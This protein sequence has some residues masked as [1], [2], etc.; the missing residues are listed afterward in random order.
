MIKQ[1]KKLLM[2]PLL[3][4]VAFIF[5]SSCNNKSTN[6][7]STPI[8][9]NGFF[10]GTIIDIKIYN[11]VDEEIFDNIFSILENIENKMSINLEE[12]EVIN[13]NNNAGNSFVKVSDET[14]YVV[15]KGLYYSELSKGN[16]DISIGPL[17]KLWGIG[18]E[19]AKVPTTEELN[20]TLENVNY[21]NVSID[22]ENSSVKLANGN[23][24]LDL[25]GIAKGYA[26]DVIASYLQE[27]GVT[28]AII[29]LGGNV[30]ALGSKGG[31]N[32]S[33]GVQ[34]P[35]D[36]RGSYFGVL[37]VKDK[38]VVTSGIYERYF[39]ENG[40]SYHHILSPYTGYPINNSLVSVSIITDN[41]IDADALST[42]TFSLGLQEGI[43]LIESIENT[44]AIFV[45]KDY[46]V[47]TTSGLKDNFTITNNDFKLAN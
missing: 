29:N 33:L 27:Q 37:N 25:G 43:N 12:S 23:M 40:V 2:L 31:K 22:E 4:I 20:S 47:Y 36:S 17:V 3:I 30:Y 16:F 39:E 34:N 26:A 15:Q 1:N 45:D 18:T 41:S 44:E 8:S 6:E 11:D 5:L 21:K 19:D 28:S 38:T 35:F 24:I 9:S 42:T 32:W 46:N 13:I 14:F 7:L 10:L